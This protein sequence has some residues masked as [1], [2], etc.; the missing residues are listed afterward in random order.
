MPTVTFAFATES[1]MRDMVV[2]AMKHAVHPVTGDRPTSVRLEISAF[3][4]DRVAMEFP[5]P[6]PDIPAL[7]RAWHAEP[8]DANRLSLW[9]AINSHGIHRPAQNG[10]SYQLGGIS[11]RAHGSTVGGEER[12][13]IERASS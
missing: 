2:E 13:T 5:E 1:S 6:K 3:S 4:D 8:N 7:I 9:K 10:R 11:Y 12:L